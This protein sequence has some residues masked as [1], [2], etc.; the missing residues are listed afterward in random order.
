MIRS[1]KGLKSRSSSVKPSSPARTRGNIAAGLIRAVFV[2]AS[3]LVV[4]GF[5]TFCF[6]PTKVN[7]AVGVGLLNIA[8]FGADLRASRRGHACRELYISWSSRRQVLT[9]PCFP[10]SLMAAKTSRCRHGDKPFDVVN[11]SIQADQV[12]VHGRAHA[13]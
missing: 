5:S 9:H 2:V 13:L 4:C 3:V 7:L 10:F 6:A 11:E 8:V 12:C 1:K